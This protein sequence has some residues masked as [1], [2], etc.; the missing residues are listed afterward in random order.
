MN[1]T[2]SET[3]VYCDEFREEY[4]I[5]WRIPGKRKLVVEY[6]PRSQIGISRSEL[7]RE[8]CNSD[9][10]DLDIPLEDV[11]EIAGPE[12]IKWSPVRLLSLKTSQPD[13]TSS[14]E[15]PNT[16]SS[17]VGTRSDSPNPVSAGTST[18]PVDVTSSQVLVPVSTTRSKPSPPDAQQGRRSKAKR[19][20]GQNSEAKRQ[21]QRREA[22]SSQTQA[23]AR[24]ANIVKAVVLRTSFLLSSNFSLNT[25]ARVTSTG[26]HGLPPPKPYL[27][28]LRARY[29]DGSINEQL[30]HFHRVPFDPTSKSATG[31]A[32]CKGRTFTIRTTVAHFLEE[33]QDELHKAMMELMQPSLVNDNARKHSELQN[34]RGC[35]FQCLMGHQRPYHEH[36]VLV[37]WHKDNEDRV[38]EFLD[39]KCIRELM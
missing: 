5:K 20:R 12:G 23:Q 34:S 21:R 11:R 39:K 15:A 32:D 31:L 7:G 33:M 30:R 14:D 27:R 37:K 1:D 38:Q 22:G 36:I 9:E 29:L 6:L 16:T 8:G 24:F 13:A 18:S 19:K 4:S 17:C 25:H 26:W 35:H 2:P 10:E 28:Q 3:D